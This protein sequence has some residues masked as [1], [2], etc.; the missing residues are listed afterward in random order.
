MFHLSFCIDLLL[1]LQKVFDFVQLKLQRLQM[2]SSD[3][4]KKERIQDTQDKQLPY[5]P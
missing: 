4:S 1:D 3:I 5:F 2:H